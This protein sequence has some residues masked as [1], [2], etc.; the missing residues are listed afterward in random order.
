[1]LT[2]LESLNY[3][4]RNP[5]NIIWVIYRIKQLRNYKKTMGS[6]EDPSLIKKR[7]RARLGILWANARDCKRG[8]L[9]V[10]MNRTVPELC[11]KFI[12]RVSVKRTVQYDGPTWGRNFRLAAWVRFRG[13][14]PCFFTA[15]LHTKSAANNNRRTMVYTKYSNKTWPS[16]NDQ[17]RS[18]KIRR[19]LPKATWRSP[20]RLGKCIISRPT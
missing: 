19:Q 3:S 9:S 2:V 1:M 18:T 16:T 20:K 11:R 8:V 15:K 13:G 10:V 12:D 17:T 5:K 7:W 4:F 6:S 14:G